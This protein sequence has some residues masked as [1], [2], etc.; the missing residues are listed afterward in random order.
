MLDVVLVF[1]LMLVLD[2]R[3]FF[4]WGIAVEEDAAAEWH[5]SASRFS[6]FSIE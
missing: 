6:L 1:V 2:V 5:V 3:D 4:A